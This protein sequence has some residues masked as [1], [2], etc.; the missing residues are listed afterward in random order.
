MNSLDLLSYMLKVKDGRFS[1]PS[2][3]TQV[4]NTYNMSYDSF[5]HTE[6]LGETAL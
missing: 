5:L 4:G 6:M 1:V 3:A 2:G